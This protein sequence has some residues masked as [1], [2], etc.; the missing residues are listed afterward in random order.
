M[1]HVFDGP[2]SS[3]LINNRTNPRK[4]QPFQLEVDPGNGNLKPSSNHGGIQVT[5]EA[6]N[7]HIEMSHSIPQLPGVTVKYEGDLCGEVVV[8]GVRTLVA[9][10]VFTVIIPGFAGDLNLE[11]IRELGAIYEVLKERSQTQE[12]WVATKP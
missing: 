2:W 7:A 5:G 12:I 9:R 4:D 1:A 11:A 6:T 10:G 3:T 8:G